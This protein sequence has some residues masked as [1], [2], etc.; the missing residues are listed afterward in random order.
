MQRNVVTLAYAS[1]AGKY[2]I[3]IHTL[4][5]T[6]FFGIILLF[7]YQIIK[8]SNLIFLLALKY[9]LTFNTQVERIKQ[10]NKTHKKTKKN[11]CN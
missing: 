11:K 4:I 1:P 3:H 10:Y 7:N 8:L 5:R 9:I 2:V 6:L